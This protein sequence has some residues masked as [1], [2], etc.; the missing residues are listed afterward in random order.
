[1]TL[2]GKE[3]FDV[4]RNRQWQRLAL[5]DLDFDEVL[6]LANLHWMGGNRATAAALYRWQH[7]RY[8]KPRGS[9]PPDAA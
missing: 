2:T 5:A 9:L 4:V 7:R 1:M 3:L 8:E 6:G